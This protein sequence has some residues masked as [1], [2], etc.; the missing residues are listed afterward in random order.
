MKKRLKLLS[1]LL[2][3]LL[4]FSGCGL[5]SVGVLNGAEEPL[6]GEVL[7]ATEVAVAP[8]RAQDD[9]YRAV[10]AGWLAEAEI[11]PNE[12]SVGSIQE[13]SLQNEALLMADFNT[14]LAGEK[15]NDDPVLEEF[16]ALYAQAKDYEKRNE[17][18]FAP[19]RP[20]FKRIE[21]LVTFA[22][23]EAELGQLIKENLTDCV[24]FSVGIN[25][26]NNSQKIV[27]FTF[28]SL[29]LPSKDY[30]E[31]EGGSEMLQAKAEVL[32]GLLLAAGYTPE[33]A[34]AT[35]EEALQFDQKLRAYSLTAEEQSNYTET[36]NPVTYE[37]FISYS[38]NIDF[39]GLVMEL[40][41]Q[42]PHEIVVNNIDHVRAI[43]KLINEESFSELKNWMLTSLLWNYGRFLGDE[44]REPIEAYENRIEGRLEAMEPEKTAYQ[45]AKG[46]FMEPVGLYYAQAYFSEEEKQDVEQMVQKI[47]DTYR[48]R[49]EALSWMSE[50]TKEKA[51]LKL[52]HIEVHVGYPDKQ[53]DFYEN[54]EIVPAE[55][56]GTLLENMMYMMRLRNEKSWAEFSL[57]PEQ[58]VWAM[59]A[60]TVNAYYQPTENSINFPAGILQ[61]PFYSAEQTA[62]QN[63]G[64]IGV[65]IAHEISHAFDTNGAL[66]DENGNI[67]NWWT[68]E[69]YAE[70]ER[71]TEAMVEL[72]EGLQNEQGT[73]DGRLTVGENVADAGGMACAL[74]CLREDEGQHDLQGFYSAWARI[75]R[76]R[77]TQEVAQIRLTTDV[78][79][80]PE[81]R[82]NLQA[83]N[84]DGFYEAFEVEPQDGMY[85]APEDRV[86][87]W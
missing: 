51:I 79:A 36:Y 4:L 9:L 31:S 5:V 16:L 42:R 86:E 33:R 52:D 17:D 76:S 30:Y 56:G 43:D 61:E 19:L 14:M 2:G 74:Q 10:N 21:G 80:P 66:Y 28:P 15:E 27:T 38:E 72:F 64:G 29:F 75:W 70:F 3:L 20:F 77:V 45:L 18:G 60:D 87:I 6:L 57:P 67:G 8:P 34:D 7:A 78:H 35:L 63:Y 62:S 12:V 1:L 50:E 55:E 39:D 69:D 24:G 49:I 82:V 48:T 11:P 13:L 54:V 44:F 22:E 84:S 25:Q 71:R 53:D 58:G 46:Q 83:G 81:F 65:V 47:I 26:M 41:G 37:E 32:H 59:S 23:F 73:V 40:L 68:E 85:I